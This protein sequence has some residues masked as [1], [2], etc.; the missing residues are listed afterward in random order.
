[1]WIFIETFLISLIILSLFLN[2]LSSLNFIKNI[3]IFTI[4]AFLTISFSWII[5]RTIIT[6]HAPFSNMYESLI[7]FGCLYLYRVIFIKVNNQ[8]T[9]ILLYIPPFFFFLIALFLP[10][11]LKE[12]LLLVP[13]LKS[14][15][16]F[17]HVPTIFVGYVSLTISF[18]YGCF[19]LYK[20]AN[21][22]AFIIR[23]LKISFYFITVG[24]ITGSFWANKSWSNFWSW[25]PKEI[26]ALVTWLL[27]VSLL[28]IKNKNVRFTLLFFG[29]FA[30][31]FTY[32]GV[33]FLLPGLH[34]YV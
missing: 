5:Y 28:H 26:W 32:F 9:N 25:D 17:I 11:A 24:I 31:L 2:I 34:S 14:P 21:F 27:L 3:K 29:F 20:N 10:T 13:V 33:M 18:F 1:M 22:D 23:E 16:I 6:T 15:W 19:L 7:F 4:I 30:M 12:P 8:L